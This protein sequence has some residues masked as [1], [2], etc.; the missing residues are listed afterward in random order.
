MTAR[1]T[2]IAWA[3]IEQLA[4]GGRLVLPIADPTRPDDAFAAITQTWDKAPRG[5]VLEHVVP[6]RF[7]PATAP[8]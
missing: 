7:V 1:F 6:S 8:R 3:W 2:E 4:M 5:L